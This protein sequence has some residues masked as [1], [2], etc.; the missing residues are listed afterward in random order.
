MP[1][2]LAYTFLFKKSSLICIGIDSVYVTIPAQVLA[3]IYAHAVKCLSRE[4]INVLSSMPSD[5]QYLTF[6]RISVHIPQ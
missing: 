4:N 6:T 1:A 5:M 2:C 3:D